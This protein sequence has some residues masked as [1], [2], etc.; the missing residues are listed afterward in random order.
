MPRSRSR[1]I[2]IHSL[3]PEVLHQIFAFAVKAD[4]GSHARFSNLKSFALVTRSWRC[5]SQILRWRDVDLYHEDAARHFAENRRTS[6]VAVRRLYMS[7]DLN[8]PGRRGVEMQTAKEVVQCCR[9][10]RDVSLCHFREMDPDLLQEEALR[11]TAYFRCRIL[12][13]PF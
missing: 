2:T 6:D 3:P 9:G 1:S 10:L 13:K 8:A 4:P 5:F 7:G 11:G 12:L